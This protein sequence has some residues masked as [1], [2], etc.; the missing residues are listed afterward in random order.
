VEFLIGDDALVA[1]LAFPD[2]GGLVLARSGQ[3]AVDAVVADVGLASGE[4]LGERRVPLEDV[5]PFLEPE[6]RR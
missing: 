6:D 5:R 2:D 1:R 4:P 3:V